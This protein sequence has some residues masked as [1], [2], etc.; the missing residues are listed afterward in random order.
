MIAI[1]KATYNVIYN[2]QIPDKRVGVIYSAKKQRQ[3]LSLL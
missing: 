2:G 1:G 3:S